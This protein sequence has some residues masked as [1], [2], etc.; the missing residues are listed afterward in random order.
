MASAMLVLVVIPVF[1]MLG[2][3][4]RL[5]ARGDAAANLHEDLRGLLDRIV[6][7]LRMAGYDPS[8]TGSATAFEVGGAAAVRFIA[9]VDGDGVTDRIE[10]A[11]DA[12]TRT[13]TRQVWQWAGAAWGGS[14]GVFVVARNV[15]GVDFGYFD[16]TDGP[17]AALADIRR[18]TLALDGSQVV[19]Q[20]GVERYSVASEARARNLL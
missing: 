18:V 1:S 14:G 13:V 2:D 11:Y 10:Y 7:E 9:D 5:F 16:A 4:Q 20:H 19:A 12:P 15:D 17:P 6:R 8:A 3:G